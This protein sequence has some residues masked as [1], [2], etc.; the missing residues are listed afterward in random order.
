MM[1]PNPAKEQWFS[2]IE[3][4]RYLGVHVETV[5][6]YIREGKLPA[7]G[8]FLRGY[9]IRLSDLEVFKAHQEKE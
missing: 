2:V 8:L 5:R 3:A 7:Q 1:Q 4:A 6:R 9:Q